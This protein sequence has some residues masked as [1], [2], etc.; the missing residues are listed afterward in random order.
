MVAAAIK[1]QR[2][3]TLAMQR[4]GLAIGLADHDPHG[5]AEACQVMGR[6]HL[7]VADGVALQQL[8][9]AAAAPCDGPGVGQP[10]H[11]VLQHPAGPV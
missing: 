6:A 10:R 4:Q 9:Q 2:A 1:G 3:A 8:G 11:G 7:P 5:P